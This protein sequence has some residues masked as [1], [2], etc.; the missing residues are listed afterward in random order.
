MGGRREGGPGGERELT[1]DEVRDVPLA[2]IGLSAFN[3]RKNLDAGTEDVSLDEL[4]DS[5]REAGLLEPPI[6]RDVGLGKYEVVAGQRRVLACRRI[7]LETIR[8]IVRDL[9][10]SEA[11]AISLI[12]NVHRADMHPLDKARAYADLLAEFGSAPEV[13]K[14]TSVNQTTV[15]KYLELLNLTPELQRE[16]DTGKGPAGVTVMSLLAKSFAGRPEEMRAV[17]EHVKG[18]TATEAE[19]VIRRAGGDA[20]KIEGLVQ[21]AAIGLFSMKMCGSSLETCPYV[22][23]HARPVIRSLVD[24]VSPAN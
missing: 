5:I 1:M 14:R 4:A 24:S 17:Y 10:D 21:Q 6:L 19:Q 16:V 9:S 3:T 13:A 12:E 8:V 18:L 7:G 20:S 11:R 15:R 22:P 23:E 2:A